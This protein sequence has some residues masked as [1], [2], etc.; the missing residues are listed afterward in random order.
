[1][2]FDEVGDYFR[3]GFRNKVM[4][5]FSESFFELQVILDDSVVHHDDA[6]G[7][8]TM[9]VGIFFGGASVRGPACMA[10]AVGP[11]QRLMPQNV[12]EISQL[13]FGSLNL[14]LMIHI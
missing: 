14:E 2:L 1:M 3:V 8:V 12:F 13:A 9:R 5:L 10:H 11:V 7:A 4:I 6:A